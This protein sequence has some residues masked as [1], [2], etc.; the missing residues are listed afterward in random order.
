MK[1][2]I[3]TIIIYR[4]CLIRIRPLEWFLTPTWHGD[5]SLGNGSKWI[6]VKREYQGQIE[7]LNYKLAYRT[8]ILI[9]WLCFTLQFTRWK[10]FKELV[11]IYGK[12]YDYNHDPLWKEKYEQLCATD[13]FN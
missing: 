8:G 2:F 6:T 5:G 10:Y 13:Y 7:Y 11:T 1:N 9:S 4:A 3:I 12:D